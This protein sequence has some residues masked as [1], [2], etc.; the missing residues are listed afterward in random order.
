MPRF[1]LDQLEV[2]DKG[3]G[4]S[5]RPLNSERK[6]VPKI[7]IVLNN[8]SIG[9]AENQL[10]Q[11]ICARPPFMQGTDV[12]VLTV[13]RPPQDESTFRE[14]LKAQ[15]VKVSTVARKDY[16][17][18]LFLKELTLT[19]KRARPDIVHTLLSSSAGTWGRL[20]AI[21]AGVPII[22][23]SDLT[24]YPQGLQRVN[25]VLRPF[26]DLRTK[27]FFPNADTIA[28][29]IIKKGVPPAKIEVI[30]CGVNLERFTPGVIPSRRREWNIPEDAV[31]GGFLAR[32][33]PVKRLDLPA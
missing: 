1:K 29:A 11:L 22:F 13:G 14:Q 27:R 7:L 10:M 16:S 4:H 8:L 6:H 33:A 15:E 30:P 28:A 32:F 24:L 25:H 31:V 26:L 20:A 9:G 18:P 17:F 19:I 5:R 12:E 2:F 23:H 21:L 3:K